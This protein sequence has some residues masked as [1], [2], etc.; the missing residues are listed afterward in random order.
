MIGIRA[1]DAMYLITEKSNESMFIDEIPTSYKVLFSKPIQ[2]V[3]P[4]KLLCPAC[5]RV[6]DSHFKFCPG[7]EEKV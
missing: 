6:V 7:C 5:S 3:L 1:A 2:S 4:T